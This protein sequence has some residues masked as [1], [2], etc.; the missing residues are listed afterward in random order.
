M[1]L[2]KTTSV[3]NYSLH[4][5]TLVSYSNSINKPKTSLESSDRPLS[6][7]VILH[8]DIQYH[9]GTVRGSKRTDVILRCKNDQNK[10][11]RF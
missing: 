3:S 7:A 11:L 6:D 8:L 5:K 4:M 1:N 9:V 10:K 2:S